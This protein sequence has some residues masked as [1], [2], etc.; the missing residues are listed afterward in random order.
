LRTGAFRPCSAGP[1][2]SVRSPG[3]HLGGPAE[4]SGT[5][6][7]VPETEKIMTVTL[8][9]PGAGVGHGRATVEIIS[10]APGRTIGGVPVRKVNGAVIRL[11]GAM[12]NGERIQCVTVER[13]GG[14]RDRAR[15]VYVMR[16]GTECITGHTGAFVALRDDWIRRTLNSGIYAGVARMR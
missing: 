2:S 9:K 8:A 1:C 3:A 12:L 16:D 7:G 13:V 10:V 4:P 6:D 14:F 11:T 15:S 5:A